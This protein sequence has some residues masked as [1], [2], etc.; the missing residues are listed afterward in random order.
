MSREYRYTSVFANVIRQFLDLKKSSGQ[1]CHWLIK[2]LKELDRIAIAERLECA[3]FTPEFLE[4]WRAT[5][6]NNAESTIY[7]KLLAWA[8]LAKYMNRNGYNTYVP[9]LPQKAPRNFAPHIFSEKEM[10]TLFHACDTWDIKAG[11]HRSL[12]FAMPVLLR[13]LYGT[14]LRIS[15]ALSIR[16]RDVNKDEQYVHIRKTKNGAERLVPISTSLLEV[17]KQ[18]ESYRSKLPVSG[19]NQPNAFY[20]VKSDGTEIQGRS[21]YT[22]FRSYLEKAGIP[23]KGK[24]HGP[25]IHDLRHTFA[26]HSLIQLDKNNID[27]YTAM[28]ILSVCLGH[29]HLIS[30]EMYVRLTSSMYPEL[31][32]KCTPINTFIYPK[33]TDNE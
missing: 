33:I 2:C 1:D 15:E 3:E 10:Q 17:M 9:P 6:I 5:T 16:N 32:K 21:V 11:H 18:Y 31:Q 7:R 29:K 19:V 4:K 20:F 27:L 30:T 26:V 22:R 28:P 25:R 8:M 24:S 14:G 23:H 12:Q 13:F